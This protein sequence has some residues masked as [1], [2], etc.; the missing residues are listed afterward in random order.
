VFQNTAGG[1]TE[2][3]SPP[4]GGAYGGGLLLDQC[5]ARIAAWGFVPAVWMNNCHRPGRRHRGAEPHALVEI[6]NSNRSHR[7][8]SQPTIP[9]A[10]AARS[11]S[12]K[13]RRSTPSTR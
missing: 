3:G 10:S 11:P 6:G 13:A 5:A 2:G 9:I 12:N 4:S 1:S 7:P 8:A